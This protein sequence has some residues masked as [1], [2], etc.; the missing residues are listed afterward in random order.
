MS[1]IRQTFPQQDA[2]L[3]QAVPEQVR[4]Q[5]AA[6]SLEFSARELAREGYSDDAIADALRIDV[7]LVR[8]MIGAEL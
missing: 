8:K 4:A 3:K 1:E 7:K 5:C 6:Q 2:P